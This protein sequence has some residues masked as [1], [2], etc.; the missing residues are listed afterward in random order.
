M[1][2]KGIGSEM[3]QIIPSS[4]LQVYCNSS[5]ITVNDYTGDQAFSTYGR[6]REVKWIIKEG[7]RKHK[8][9]FE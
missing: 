6:D 9:L 8:G 4:S 5:E 2:R 3:A 1:E 7:R